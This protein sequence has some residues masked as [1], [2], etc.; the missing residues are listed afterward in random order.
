MSRSPVRTRRSRAAGSKMTGRYCGRTVG[1]PNDFGN[2][3]RVVRTTEL[4]PATELGSVPGRI[5]STPTELLPW[6]VVGPTGPEG[7]YFR[8]KNEAA[9]Y[10]VALYQ[11][12]LRHGQLPY[13]AAQV[14]EQLAGLDL[15]CY[16]ALDAP[17]HVDVLLEVAN[18]VPDR[19]H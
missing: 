14:R 17:C 3:W 7:I 9:A 5:R 19:V 12:A 18:L 15:S 8:T 6:A 11:R 4:P 2:P 1:H 16:C 13:T 10:A